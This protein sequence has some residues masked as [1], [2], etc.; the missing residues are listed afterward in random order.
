MW[1][2]FK[3]FALRG[4]VVDMAVGVIVGGAFGKIVTSLVNDVVM[5]ILGLL[6]GRVD[7]TSLKLVLRQAN[8]TTAELALTYGVFLQN[9]LDF[10]IIS[11]SIFMAIRM[12]N[13]VRRKEEEA[14]PAP[15]APPEPSTEEKL[16]TEIRD[17]LK[18]QVGRSA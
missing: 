6:V 1:Q 3:K 5:P 2:E 4:N 18:Q 17:L 14:P 16:L 15:E 12:I 10:L 7:L 8:D 13:K 11:F 9:V